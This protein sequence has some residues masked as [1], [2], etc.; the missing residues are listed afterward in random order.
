MSQENVEVVMRW[1][2]LLA[3]GDSDADTRAQAFGA[4]GLRG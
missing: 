2:E 1:F 3:R 4:V